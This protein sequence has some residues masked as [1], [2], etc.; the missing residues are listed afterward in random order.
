[1][2]K[3][4]YKVIQQEV[5]EHPEKE[6]IADKIQKTKEKVEE[7]EKVLIG[8]PP[9]HEETIGEYAKRR[10]SS[11]GSTGTGEK[12]RHNVVY[13]EEEITAVAE[14]PD[15][16]KTRKASLEDTEE[17]MK[18]L[19]DAVENMKHKMEHIG[20]KLERK[21]S[22]AREKDTH[23]E[24]EAA[25]KSDKGEQP[26]HGEQET[27]GEKIKHKLADTGKYIEEVEILTQAHNIQGGP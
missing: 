20:E 22:D 9:E 10:R 13:T 17:K 25:G 6:T 11:A 15:P 2:S 3:V 24:E 7:A 16:L 12:I 27:P 23:M 1:M 18:S 19:V 8:V 5:E 21:G 4:Q 14:D 26:K